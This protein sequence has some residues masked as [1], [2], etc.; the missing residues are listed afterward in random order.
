MNTIENPQV[1]VCVGYEQIYDDFKEVNPNDFLKNVPTVR[2]LEFIV[3]RQNKVIY[4]FSNLEEQ[5]N[6]FY[7][8]RCYIKTEEK[9]RIDSF[10]LRHDY[11]YFMDNQSCF[12]FYMLALQ[13]NNKINRELTIEDIQNIYKAYLYCSQI[14][15]NNQLITSKEFS[16]LDEVSIRIDLPIVLRCIKTLDHNSTKH[17]DFFHFVIN[18]NYLKPL[19]NGFIKNMVFLIALII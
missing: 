5:K 1:F 19:Q 4:S 6:F 14:W 16:S 10:L 2:A 7:E 15:T 8:M 12:L 17:Q 18:T 9:C 11:P 3:E 13:N